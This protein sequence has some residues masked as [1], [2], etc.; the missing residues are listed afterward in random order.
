MNEPFESA[1]ST[2]RIAALLTDL[3]SN[4]EV[5]RK[6]AESQ[7]RGIGQTAVGPLVQALAKGTATFC[8]PFTTAEVSYFDRAKID[9][10]RTW[11]AARLLY[12]C[13]AKHHGRC[14]T[15][16]ANLENKR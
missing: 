10:A 5:A 2:G 11:V 12:V 7:F 15:K 9:E 6:R 4:S 14:L 16:V 1:T 8:K 3:G 13:G